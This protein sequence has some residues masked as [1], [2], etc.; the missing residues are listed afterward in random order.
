MA[1]VVNKVR[2]PPA[3]SRD[4]WPNLISAWYQRAIVTRFSLH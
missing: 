4:I 2:I 3:T 1:I